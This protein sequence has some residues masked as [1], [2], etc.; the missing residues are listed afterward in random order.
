MIEFARKLDW[1]LLHT[2]MVVVHQKSITR[3]ADELSRSQ[4]AV[5]LA[6]KR[7][8]DTVGSALL[9]RESAGLRPTAAGEM[10]FN[11]ACSIYASISRLPVMLEDLPQPVTGK[12]KITTI[13]N[14]VSAKL[15]QKL[16][17]FFRR[18]PQVD[19]EMN[20]TTTADILHSVEVG[21]CTI[22]I[23]DGVIPRQMVAA[24][25]CREVF[26]LFCGTGH[27]LF[28]REGLALGDL[29]GE[30]F[31]GFTA[32]VL[33]GEHMTEVT[34]LRAKASIGQNVRGTSS[35]VKEVLRMIECGV[36]IGFLPLHIAREAEQ[37]GRIWRLPP[38]EELPE[39]AV[40]YVYNP[41]TSFSAVERL[42]IDHL[43][44]TAL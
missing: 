20:V 34:A 41:G 6:I 22:G 19:L 17:E 39:S 29:R 30:P 12:I 28:G 42:F 7:L 26:A 44:A 27:P 10:L 33:G 3:A 16:V 11:E 9:I 14:V 18:Y 38:Y 2:F 13:D 32:D 4:P 25:L 15:D 40:Y 24:E 23:Y 35:N 37:T 43:E 5:S 31:I 36:G 1:N 21:N 8:E